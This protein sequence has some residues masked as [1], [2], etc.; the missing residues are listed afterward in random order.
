MSLDIVR[1]R[2]Q[3]LGLGLGGF[4]PGKKQRALDRVT[5]SGGCSLENKKI[6]KK[7]KKN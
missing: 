4:G 3:A 5:S 7:I 1:F 6:K 2:Q